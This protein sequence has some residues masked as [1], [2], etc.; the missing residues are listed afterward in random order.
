MYAVS[1]IGSGRKQQQ[2][3]SLHHIV[4]PVVKQGMSGKL[5]S[6]LGILCAPKVALHSTPVSASWNHDEYKVSRSSVTE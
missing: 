5:Q 1:T 3:H 2:R 4:K 6:V